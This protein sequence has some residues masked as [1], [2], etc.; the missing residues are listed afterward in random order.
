MLNNVCIAAVT[1]SN[2]GDEESAREEF[3]KFESMY[4]N[5]GPEIQVADVDVVKQRQLLMDILQVAGK[6]PQPVM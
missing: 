2:Y 5:A 6:R 1:L 3:S 4:S